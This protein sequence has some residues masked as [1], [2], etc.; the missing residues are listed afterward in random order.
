MKDIKK[1]IPI[2]RLLFEM[3]SV[4]FAI[5]LALA[6]NEWRTIR[7]NEKLANEALKKISKEI[8][9]NLEIVK[10]TLN[11]NRSIKEKQWKAYLNLKKEIDNY[12]STNVDE[13]IGAKF[14]FAFMT[15][16][17]KKTAWNS[18][19]LTHAVEY[20]D[21]NIVEVL[22]GTVNIQGGELVIT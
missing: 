11:S 3:F 9:S 16:S 22:S 20:L 4:I 15:K 19:N 2:S 1:K 21:F 8:V 12:S 6:A 7:T 17:I 5:L 14:P 18:A 13:Q 10:E